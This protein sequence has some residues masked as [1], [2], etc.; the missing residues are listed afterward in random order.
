MRELFEQFDAKAR[1]RLRERIDAGH[2]VVL[3]DA[4]PAEVAQQAHDE[5][6]AAASWKR[7]QASSPFFHYQHHNIYDDALL[8]PFV[9]SLKACFAGTAAKRF[10]AE[11]GG[12]DCSGPLDFGA[13]WYQPGDHS[14]PHQDFGLGRSVAWVWNLTQTWDP[15]WGGCFFW[16]PSGISVVPRLNSLIL[17]RVTPRSAHFV[18][19][20]AP[21]AGGKRLAL[22]GWWTTAEALTT[23]V[24]AGDG[25]P[26]LGHAGYG[27]ARRERIGE[28]DAIVL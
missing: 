13:S 8:P 26:M 7:Y 4:F 9:R 19:T 20:V 24:P 22:N 28:H 12:C 14:L 17:F 16:C 11:I 10:A 3:P 1:A 2:A 15:S 5:L 18:T 25:D 6:D 27:D 23:G 21:E